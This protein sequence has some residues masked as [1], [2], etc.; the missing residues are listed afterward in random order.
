MNRYQGHYTS[1][2]VDKLI[3]DYNTNSEWQDANISLLIS[4]VIDLD[5]RLSEAAKLIPATNA[6]YV[7]N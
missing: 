3:H 2:A 4:E 6:E 7:N 1:T 5:N